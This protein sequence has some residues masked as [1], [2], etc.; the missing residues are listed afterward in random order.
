MFAMG[1]RISDALLPKFLRLVTDL[2]DDEVAALL[3]P[4]V[5]PRDAKLRMAEALVARYHGAAAGAA[6]RAE[7]LRVH[8]EKREPSEVEEVAVEGTELAVAD[9]VVRCGL[10][11]SK[12][13]ARRLIGQGGVAVND[14]VVSDPAERLTPADG[15]L[16][17]VGRRR[18][19]RLRLR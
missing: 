6:Q 2:P 8:S 16:V 18:F 13:E 4:G 10:A 12:S 1:M 7:W 19:A 17:R 15:D 11:P 5:H 3:A 9:L 14:R